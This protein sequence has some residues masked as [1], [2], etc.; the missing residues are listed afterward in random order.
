MHSPQPIPLVL[1]GL[2]RS[3]YTRIVRLV[4]EEKRL[5]YS[6]EEVDIF[7]AE[8]VPDEHLQRHP[9]G[10]IPVLQHGSFMLYETSAIT[11]YIDEAFPGVGLQPSAPSQRAR[12]NQ[13]IGLLD[14]Y[15]YR[16]MV[17][18]VFVQRVRVPLQGGVANE[19][20]IVDA[21][22][23]A[24]TCLKAME[25]LLEGHSFLAGES[26]SLADLHALPMLRYFCL[27]PEGYAMF[28]PHTGLLRWYKAMLTRHSVVHTM[29]QYEAMQS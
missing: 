8:G 14:A 18:G 13:I 17:W 2:Q 6:L 23:V 11:R 21:L 12:M 24:A 5:P 27:A 9:F 20:E 1:F 19:A 3:V 15:A 4:L 22:S 29:T 10:R 26:L 16:S 28:K 7:G 25:G